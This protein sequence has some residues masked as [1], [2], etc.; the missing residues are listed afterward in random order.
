MFNV[1]RRSAIEVDPV[2]NA[3]GVAKSGTAG[4]HDSFCVDR[5][6]RVALLLE[7]SRRKDDYLVAREI[8]TLRI[9]RHRRK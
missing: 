8:W 4:H 7:E 2:I 6:A 9:Y 5:N 1:A 3:G